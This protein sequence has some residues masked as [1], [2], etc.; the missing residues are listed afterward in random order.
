[1]RLSLILLCF[2]LLLGSGPSRA[3]TVPG[4]TA[5]SFAD[6]LFDEGDYY[7]AITEYTRFIHHRNAAA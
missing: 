2:L 6:S 4:E 1:M 7:R 3:Q 5:L